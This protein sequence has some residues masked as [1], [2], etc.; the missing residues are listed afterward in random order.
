MRQVVA[1]FARHRAG[2]LVLG[3]A[4]LILIIGSVVAVAS[5]PAMARKFTAAASRG[6][7]TVQTVSAQPKQ[8]QKK[9]VF[10]SAKK[11]DRLER[12][13]DFRSPGNGMIKLDW[14]DA[15]SSAELSTVFVPPTFSY[16]GQTRNLNVGG[17]VDINPTSGPSGNTTNI[18]IVNLGGFPGG[19][20]TVNNMT[21]FVQVFNAPNAGTFTITI[22][23]TNATDDPDTFTD[24][25]FTL[26][27]NGPPTITPTAGI[28]RQAGAAGM[29]SQ[30]ATVNDDF[31]TRP[32]L[33][34]RVNG[35]TSATVNGV[36]VTLN[37]VQPNGTGQVFADIVAGCNA[38]NATFGLSVADGSGL[39]AN[40]SL[41]ISVTPNAP[42]V[43]T[44][45]QPMPPPLVNQGGSL[46][47]NPAT[48]PSDD[49]GAPALTVAATGGYSGNICIFGGMPACPG[50]GPAGRVV[51]TNAAPGGAT[52]TIIIRATDACGVTTDAPFKVKINAPPS[53][54]PVPLGIT[55]GTLAPLNLT[56]ANVNDPEDPPTALTLSLAPVSGSGVTMTLSPTMANASGTVTA[57]LT[58]SCMAT[59]STFNLTATDTNG[60][61]TTSLIMVTVVPNAAPTLSYPSPVAVGA[62]GGTTIFPA[63][64]PTD[65]GGIAS[66]VVQSN[67]GFPGSLTVNGTTAVVTISGAPMTAA[68]YNVIIRATDTCGAVRDATFTLNIT[69]PMIGFS[70]AATAASV[71][72]GETAVFKINFENTGNQD[73][74]NAVISE[75]VPANTTFSAAGSSGL[76]SCAD[77]S[78]AG[79]TCTYTV[80]GIGAGGSGFIF[81]AVNVV[82]PIAIGVTQITNTAS[83]SDTITPATQAMASI[84]IAAFPDMA[85]TKTDGGITSGAGMPIPYTIGYS[86]V[87]RRNAAGVVITE[88]VPANTTFDA[89]ASTAGW[90]CANGSPGGT[91]CTF[92]VG[93]VTGSGG[94]GTLTFVVNVV[95][96]LP[97]NVTQVTNTASISEG[98][99]T[100]PEPDNNSSSD[101]TPVGNGLLVMPMA[102]G[103]TQ[104]SPATNSVIATVTDIL[105]PVSSVIVT[106]TAVP[107]G[108]TISNITNNGSG[109]INADIAAG[110]NA[111]IGPN[112]IGL[113]A[114]D[115]ANNMTLVNLTV[116]VAANTMPVLGNYPAT[117]PINPGASTTVTPSAAPADNGSVASITAAAPGFT[118]T[119]SANPATGVVNV[120]NAGPS[121]TF[122]VTV[123]AT[124]NCGLAATKTFSLVVNTPPTITP[125]G[126]LSLSQGS[127]TPGV[128]VATVGDINTTAGSLIVTM[129]SAPPGILLTSFVNSGGTITATVAVA[130]TA[131][132]GA[133]TVALKVTDGGGL[134]TNGSLIVNVTANTA[135]VQGNYSTSNV[136]AGAGTTITPSAAPADNGFITGIVATAPGFTGGF[137]VDTVTGVITVANAGP[138]GAFTVT[139]TA[140]D[141]CGATSIRTF[142]LNVNCPVITV[143]APG[144]ATGTVNAPFNQSFTQAG[145]VGAV[146]FTLSSGTLPAGLILTANG[147]L[148]GTPTQS[149]SFPITVTATDSNGCMGTSGVYTLVINCQTITVNPPPIATGTVGVAFSQNF[150]QAGGLGAVNYT[151]NSGTIPAGMSLAANGVLSGT[152]TQS[153]TFPITVKVTDVNGC[154]GISA[155]FT[156]VINCQ[157]IAVTPPAVTTG[158]VSSFF[159]QS[160]T[161]QGSIGTATYTLNSGTLPTGITLAVNGTLA[162]IPTQS[163][164]FPITVKVTD[165]NGC[166]GISPTY[167]LVIGC[168]GITVTPPAVTTG[169]ANTPFSQ[170][171]TQS[172]GLGAITFTI[173]TGTLPAG[174]TLSPAGVLSGTPTQ[175]GSFNIT[176]NATDVNGCA[177]ISPS[178]TL[179]IGCQTITVTPP[180]VTT[181]AIGAAFSQ[182]FTQTAAIGAVTFSI[183]SGSLPPGLTLA[184]NGL[185]SGMPTQLG[186]FP[187][188]VKV[189]DA[190]GCMGV[191]PTTTFV[192]TC[193]TITVTPPAVT[194]G[195][196]GTVFSQSFS[197]MGAIGP[198]TFSLNSGTLPTGLSLSTTGVLSG[199]PT[200]FG[201]YPLTVKVTDTNGCTGISPV[202]N[203]VINC[204][205]ITVTAPAVAT[206]TVGAPFNQSFTQAG[207]LGATSFTLNSGTIAPGLVLGLN[208]QLSG[209]PIQAGSFPITVKVTDANGCMGISA[210]YTLVV[211]C[212]TITFAPAA[213]PAGTY[214]DAYNQ[215]VT[216]SPGGVYNYAVTAGALPPGLALNDES[217]AIT[218]TPTAVGTYPFTITATYYNNCPASMTYTIVINCPVV[219]L[220]PANLTEGTIGVAYSQTVTASPAGTYGYAV[221]TGSLPPGVTLNTSTGAISGTPT[222]IGTYN[223]TITATGAGGLIGCTGSRD[224][225]I[226]INC[227][228]ITVT[229]PTTLPGGKV[230]DPYSQTIGATPANTYTFTVSNGSL[231]TGLTLNASTGVIS[232]TPTMAG[233]FTFTIQAT[234]PDTCS[235]TQAYT[236]EINCPTITLSPATLPTGTI[237]NAYPETNFAAAP[238]GTYSFTVTEGNLPA[239]LTLSSAGV[240]SG[241]ATQ[242]GN[243]PITVTATDANQCTG[244]RS[245]TLGINI[246]PSITVDP[247]TVPAGTVG[248]AYSQT[249]TATGST[250][251]YTFTVSGQPLPNGLALSAAGVLS[252]T[253]TQSGVYSFTVTATDANNCAG[254][255]AYTLTINLPPGSGNGLQ[256]FP[257]TAPVRLLDTRAGQIG[258]EAPGTPIP[259]GTSRT[260]VA[261]RMCDGLII[262]AGAMA[263][264]GNITSVQSGGGY[265]TLYPSDASQPTVANS[266]YAPNEV[267]NNVF[268]VGLGDAD[269]A[270]KIFVTSTTDVVVDVTGYYAPPEPGGLYFHPLPK[271]IRLLET[272]AGFTGCFSPGTQILG[273]TD[274]AQQARLT[275]DG[276]TIP[277]SARSIV[278]NATTVNTSGTGAQFMT[279]FPAVAAR[280]LAAS[281]NYN[282]G[283]V[284]NA[285]FTVG[286]SAAGAFNIF[287]TSNTDLVI[288]VLGYYSPDATDDN[289]LGLLFNSLP[290]PVRLLETR[291]QF[292]GCYNPGAPIQGGVVRLQP[293][294]GSCDGVPI[295]DNALA[296]VGNATVLNGNGGYLTFW[297]STATQPTVAASNFLPGQVFNRHFTVGLGAADGAFRIFSQFTTDLVIDVSGYFAP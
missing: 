187:V 216:A 197:Q 122:T 101:T 137:I 7:G 143:T 267:L 52:P 219:T 232:G 230:G 150:A 192:I 223:F 79:T 194:T 261:R 3:L 40:A 266:N 295:A 161:Q 67:G 4:T 272:R 88:T 207:A 201:T 274:T 54:S 23:A 72:P 106:T 288:D 253:P 12:F 175:T 87:G 212:P 27:V 242:S 296:L 77:G 31:T 112:T 60:L 22:R 238:T 78:P 280:P 25:S 24:A 169:T 29:N 105:A 83:Y 39:I 282:P 117:G 172:A 262:P 136:T 9:N 183:N 124:D 165:S 133:N 222:L 256:F 50:M 130:C 167:T 34:V 154:M 126:P 127:T 86:N 188:T 291:P 45:P 14:L 38:G 59:N 181:G 62:G 74:A 104:G 80:G 220:A 160:F 228:T 241:T 255:R 204:Q 257:L 134:T 258:C 225:T 123:T 18:A 254:S 231:P 171:F 235:G 244:S 173:N 142:T 109:I 153:G 170:S 184:A 66:I 281:S 56:I 148:S 166:T 76:W 61:S 114:T 252:G 102:V 287:A 35:L 259:G 269:G 168:Q 203:L 63:S 191:S 240:L 275:C 250:A 162:G 193:Q 82:N 182:S 159:N 92:S 229:P 208:G 119:F 8:V 141:N 260:Q 179:V 13:L 135:P 177:G 157:N 94:S 152:P 233:S 49:L 283:Q 71:Q 5:R 41:S 131:T 264:T 118:G 246:C 65:T 116:N 110:C 10:S 108:I 121:G 198:F 226:I 297:P 15:A 158:T 28:T 293:A 213:L 249:F 37:P 174:L 237:G 144:V 251:P 2:A 206:A 292:N 107:T 263:I 217:G 19:N 221:T 96:S 195:T 200:Q 53:V 99:G 6:Q 42:P 100:D 68:S 140:T 199:T 202:Y 286:L 277:A 1:K 70:K 189:T 234:D 48:G 57:I 248:T 294:R 284:M 55:Q 273:G 111:A 128:T 276:V 139:V 279:L 30:I 205:V 163:G 289:G 278:G 26:I 113:K 185:V 44:Y 247:Q 138:M 239:G 147:V 178:Y 218:G 245:Y 243:F 95:G 196:V 32:N 47:I 90:S 164:N 227:R 46:T 84:A 211:S 75:T 33:V 69:A 120:S 180:A 91:T 186:S 125:A 145:G 98:S 93:N 224:Y 58:A 285:P 89:A 20:I 155:T 43:L 36:T 151:L 210:T 265:L 16:G 156:L 64:G 236:V 146:A 214:G 115:S 11:A 149:G 129:D 85:V 190:N 51:L 290:R 215:T 132:L 271:P 209:T 81:F 176:V 97:V 21:G 103:R 270:F 73:A 17:S 268:T